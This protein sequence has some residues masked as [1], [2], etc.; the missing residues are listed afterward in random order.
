MN[1]SIFILTKAFI[2]A[3]LIIFVYNIKGNM[4]YKYTYSI[5]CFLIDWEEPESEYTFNTEGITIDETIRNKQVKTSMFCSNYELTDCV[6]TNEHVNSEIKL[7]KELYYYLLY[8]RFSTIRNKLNIYFIEENTIKP[9]KLSVKVKNIHVNTF[10]LNKYISNDLYI[11]FKLLEA[12]LGLYNTSILKGKNRRDYIESVSSRL[13]NYRLNFF[14]I[15]YYIDYLYRIKKDDIKTIEYINIVISEVIKILGRENIFKLNEL[16][17]VL[18]E[19]NDNID[20]KRNIDYHNDVF[21]YMKK[22]VRHVEELISCIFR[23]VHY[24]IEWSIINSKGIDRLEEDLEELLMTYKPNIQETK[25]ENDKIISL[26]DRETILKGHYKFSRDN[27]RY[28]FDYL[29]ELY[30]IFNIGDKKLC[31]QK[32]LGGICAIIYDSKVITDCN[33]FSK[34]M[35]LLCG[36]WKRETPKDCRLNKYQDAKQELLDKHRILN[37]IP[38]K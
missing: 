35:Y 19:R 13:E 30:N 1:I 14:Y 16:K 7:E 25:K 21:H 5:E 6:I 12:G 29:N 36:Y 11:Y 18:S 22:I 37:E 34:C 33:T 26:S 4:N 20:I 38:R 27:E 24:E 23:I 15:I 9:F 2:L 17:C 10:E 3:V 8:S 28:L 32:K 31:N